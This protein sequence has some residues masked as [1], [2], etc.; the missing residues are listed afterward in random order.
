M[1]KIFLI[2]F[3]LFVTI[4]NILSQ[5]KENDYLVAK[6][7][8]P[9]FGAVQ[10]RQLGLNPNNTQLLSNEKY[11]TSPF[12]QKEFSKNGYF[13]DEIFDWFYIL[14][15]QEWERFCTKTLEENM[16][17]ETEYYFEDGQ[18]PIIEKIKVNGCYFWRSKILF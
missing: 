18:R 12:V 17:L 10:F 6:I 13:D 4:S 5:M 2:A 3:L 9:T 7:N 16:M 11:K 8:N 14:I 1:N 15:K